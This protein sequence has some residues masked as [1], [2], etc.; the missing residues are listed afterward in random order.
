MAMLPS[1]PGSQ[2]PPLTLSTSAIP[3]A[4][5]AGWLREVICREYANVEVT[6]PARQVLS[7]DLA[8]Y[9]F[10]DLRLS[11][12]RSSG[13]GLQRRPSS[14]NWQAMTPISPSCC[15]P[16][17]MC[18]SRTAMRPCCDPATWRSTTRRGHTGSIARAI[19]QSSFCRFPRPL[20]RERM[21]GIERCAALRISGAA[22]VGAVAS[23]FMRD[24]ARTPAPSRRMKA[25]R[26][27][28]RRSIS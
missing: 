23:N 21:A 24:A 2:T 20:L 26:S 6:S 3:P 11:V 15:C 14:R 12:I 25:R 13:I 28:I 7:Q 10:N 9:P 16:A 19:F 27:P 5:R 8:I 18:W 17:T 4:E 1:S 22:G